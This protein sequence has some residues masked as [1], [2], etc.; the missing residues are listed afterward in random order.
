MPNPAKNEDEPVKVVSPLDKLSSNFMSSSI[1]DLGWKFWGEY[2]KNCQIVTVDLTGRE[3]SLT[4]STWAAFYVR[5]LTIVGGLLEG[6]NAT[7][8]EQLRRL[9]D[10][11]PRISS[12]KKLAKARLEDILA[13]PTLLAPAKLMPGDFEAELDPQEMKHFFDHYIK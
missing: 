10:M 8:Y 5:D 2:G 3:S 4:P 1:L 12:V 6:G 9:V 13:N 11:Q 7:S